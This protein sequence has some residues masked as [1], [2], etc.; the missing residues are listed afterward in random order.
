M[1]MMPMFQMRLWNAHPEPSSV[2]HLF[3]NAALWKIWFPCPEIPNDHDDDMVKRG[4]ASKTSIVL[5]F[6]FTLI[7]QTGAPESDF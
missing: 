4:Q 2:L 5:P 7:L 3:C 6:Q 1:I